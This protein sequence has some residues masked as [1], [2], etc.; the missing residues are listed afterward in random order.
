MCDRLR[1]THQRRERTVRPPSSEG[2]SASTSETRRRLAGVP[3][4]QGSGGLAER[5]RRAL[6]RHRAGGLVAVRRA[7]R[8]ADDGPARGERPHLH[9]VAHDGAVLPDALDVPHRAQP[10]PERIRDDLR[11]LDRIP[12]LQLAHPA[13]ERA[14]WRACCAR[15]AGA[16]SGSARTTTCRSTSGPWAP[17]RR[18][19]RSG[20]ATTG[21]TASS[22]ARPTTGIRRWPRTTTTSTS[23]TGPRT[24]TTCPRISRTR[25]CG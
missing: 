12:R 5:P 15:P 3:A 20:R 10:P 13:G 21:S 17:R 24:A 11:V 23:P 2:R 25:R 9:P 8:D 16:R 18:T 7:D 14:R 1:A 4:R 6:R 22:A 19:G